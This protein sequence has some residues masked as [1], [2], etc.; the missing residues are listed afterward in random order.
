MDG[1]ERVL[2]VNN[3]IREFKEGTVVRN[4][5][6]IPTVEKELIIEGHAIGDKPTACPVCHNRQKTIVKL[7][8]EIKT[9]KSMFI[10][11]R[12]LDNF[13]RARVSSYDLR[14]LKDRFENA[15]SQMIEFFLVEEDIREEAVKIIENMIKHVDDL[16]KKYEEQMQEYYKLSRL[17][18]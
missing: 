6:Y 16:T 4:K 17:E 12:Q 8:K 14:R 1:A 15:Y 11:R 2:T 5:K 9:L 18:K 10:K 3:S 13:S 7:K